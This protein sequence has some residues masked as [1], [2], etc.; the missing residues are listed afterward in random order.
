MYL[1][2]LNNDMVGFQNITVREIIEHL[3]LTFVSII[4]VDLEHNF[5]HM[6]KTWDPKQPMETLFKKI[7]DCADFCEAGGVTIDQ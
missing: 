5:E 1:E 3:F 7:Q 6:P 4:A 2:I